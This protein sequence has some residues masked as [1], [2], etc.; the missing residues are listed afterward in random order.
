MNSAYSSMGSLLAAMH[1]LFPPDLIGEHGWEK[2][3]ALATRLPVCAA[4]TRFGFE[5]DLSDPSPTADL[6]VQCTPGSPLA[7]FYQDQAEGLATSLMGPGLRDFLIEQDHCP[8]SF[9]RRTG[10]GVILEYEL[11][12][13]P[14][15]RHGPPGVFIVTP[16][17][18]DSEARL[19]EDPEALVAALESAAGWSPGTVDMG[20]VRRVWAAASGGIIPQAG[21]M[22]GR[23]R[24]ALRFIIHGVVEAEVSQ[25]LKKL[26]WPGDSSQAQAFQS[27]L[28]G[29]VVPRAALSI[30]VTSLGVSPRLGL[31]LFRPVERR[32]TDRAGWKSLIERLVER[33]WCLESKA[34][35]LARWP[36]VEMFFGRDGVYRV[37]QVINHFKLLIHGGDIRAKGYAAMD[38]QRTAA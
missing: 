8:K 9:L 30:D 22:P 31:E 33:A 36:R 25:T 12:G 15:A 35:A 16:G 1:G 37:R 4:D 34:D 21:V 7:A 6:C 2:V 3:Q 14:P 27:A 19:D 29:L 10:A 23:A 20:P 32:R 13:P 28:A 24:K 5:F 38:V 26:Q 17:R 11:A 18:P